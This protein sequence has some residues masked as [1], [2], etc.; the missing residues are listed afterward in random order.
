VERAFSTTMRHVPTDENRRAEAVRVGI[1]DDDTVLG[2]ALARAASSAEGFA[3]VGVAE[4]LADGKKLLARGL[5]VLLVDLGLPDGSGLE[6]VASASALGTCKVLVI[7]VF[8]DARTVVAA[9]ERGAD[10]YLLKGADEPE[11]V[12]AIRTVLDGGAP[13]SP[14]VAGHILSRV[15]G[16]ASPRPLGDVETTHAIRI[17][18]TPREVAVLELLAKG[19]SFKEVAAC[20]GISHHTVGDHVKSIYRKLSVSSRGEAVYEA[21]KAGLIDVKE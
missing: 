10:G 9:I 20:E 15:R 14:S 7:S 12:A 11:V 4:S 19:L 18:L 17:A 6:L 3:L 1:V 5:D 8:G 21:M 16:S 13:I 2:D